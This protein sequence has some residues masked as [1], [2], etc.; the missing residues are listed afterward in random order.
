MVEN[1]LRR[2][3]DRL[4]AFLTNFHNDKE[5]EQFVDEKQ[6]VLQIIEVRQDAPL[7]VIIELLL[8]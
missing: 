7:I 6:Y 1:I 2:N 5:D 8:T 4:I 3:R